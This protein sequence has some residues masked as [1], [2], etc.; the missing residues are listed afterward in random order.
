MKND[1]VLMHEIAMEFVHEA[2]LAYKKGDFMMAKLFY[3]KAYAIEKEYAFKIPKDKKYE[4]TRSIIFRSAATLALNSGYFDEAIQMVQSA[5]RA[6]THPAIVPELKEVQKKAQKELKNGTAN[7]M[8]KI[9]GTLIGADL[10]NRTLKVL[11]RDGRQYYGISAT[12]ENIIEIVKSFWTKKVEIK[13]KTIKDGTINL[14]GIRQV[15]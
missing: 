14:E 13:G 5:L 6:G 1:I 8:T 2:E 10:P 12:K 4:L 7:S 3:Q 9:T 11:G 15:A